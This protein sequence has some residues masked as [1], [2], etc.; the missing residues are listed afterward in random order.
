MQSFYNIEYLKNR[1][2]RTFRDDY[3][4]QWSDALLDEIIF[5]AQ[6]EYA[7]YS[8]CLLGKTNIVSQNNPVLDCPDGFIKI[9]QAFDND[10]KVLPVV[11]FRRLAADYGDFRK[12]TGNKAKCLVFDF[13]DHKKFRIF[14]Q[15]PAGIKIG[16]MHYQ[17]LPESVNIEVKNFDAVEAYSLYMMFLMVGKDIATVWY[18][19]FIELVNKDN[20]AFYNPGVSRSVKSGRYF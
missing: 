8:G 17:R 10:G 7:L 1:L 2:R 9:V 15:I 4:I 20:S 6:R 19:K 14:P 11:S 12:Q 16:V 18:E 3:N 5:E 13:D